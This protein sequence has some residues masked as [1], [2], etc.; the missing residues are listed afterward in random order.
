MEVLGRGGIGERSM[1][2]LD[3]SNADDI[4]AIFAVADKYFVCLLAWDATGVSASVIGAVAER[5]IK[6][7]CVYALCWGP[8]CERVHDIFDEEAVDMRTDGPWAMTNW[9]SEEPLVD[10]IWFTLICACP[11]EA[12][13][14]GCKSTI[15][16]SIGST[17]WAS[18]IRTAFARPADFIAYWNAEDS[19]D[20]DPNY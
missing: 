14:E 6:A 17:E 18:E 3:V 10:A 12:F 11:D 2:L 8:D 1:F 4:P 19:R 15:G 16:I 13:A 20:E 9:H 7:G 5:L